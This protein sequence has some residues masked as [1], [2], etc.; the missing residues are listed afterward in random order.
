M[1]GSTQPTSLVCSAT[2]AV[3]VALI[4]VK[5]SVC[6]AVTVALARVSDDLYADLMTTQPNLPFQA[7]EDSHRSW[8]YF[9]VSGLFELTTTDLKLKDGYFSKVW[10]IFSVI[11]VY[12]INF[13]PGIS[14]GA[15]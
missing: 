5:M 12:K 15:T 13:D 9:R 11:I 3:A 14:K 1:G 2:L 8:V 4:S 7:A 10:W 6:I